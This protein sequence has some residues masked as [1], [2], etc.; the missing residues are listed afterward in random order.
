MFIVADI[1]NTDK[2]RV[3]LIYV[4]WPK[5]KTNATRLLARDTAEN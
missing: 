1:L 3:I 4:Y 2:Q 5:Q